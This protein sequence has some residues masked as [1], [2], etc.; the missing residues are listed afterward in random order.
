MSVAGSTETYQIVNGNITIQLYAN[1][2]AQPAGTYY[3]AK[4]ELENGAVYEE[5]WIVPN[6]P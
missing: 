2:N 1:A 4:Y 6:L 3:T 5:Y